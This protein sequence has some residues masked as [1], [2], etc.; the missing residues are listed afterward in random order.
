M[1]VEALQ[2]QSYSHL[3]AEHFNKG[4]NNSFMDLENV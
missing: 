4:N 1:N 2:Q 3:V